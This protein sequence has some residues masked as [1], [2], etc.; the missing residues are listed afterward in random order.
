M[1]I[2]KERLHANIEANNVSVKE[3]ISS[4]LNSIDRLKRDIERYANQF[5]QAVSNGDD[6]R[7]YTAETTIKLVNHEIQWAVANM[8]PTLS[9]A[10][11]RAV[12]IAV[13]KALIKQMETE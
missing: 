1:A 12:E 10:M 8:E 2:R 9:N 11:T 6:D 4:V 3:S 13:N 5:D 7:Y